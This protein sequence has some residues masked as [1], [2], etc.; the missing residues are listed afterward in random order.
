METEQLYDLFRNS[1]GVSTDSRR[2]WS[3][4]L[5][6]ALKGD[7]FNGN[8]YAAAALEAGAAYAVVDDMEVY[9]SNLSRYGE[10]LVPVEN[11]LVAL[12][13][14]AKY[15]RLKHRLPVIAITGT[16]GKTTTKELVNAVLSAKYRTVCTE[17]NLNNHIGVPLTLLKI[18]DTTD[19][20]VVEMGASAPGEIAALA[21]LVC[22]SFGLIT[23]VGR[24]HLLGFGTFEGVKKTKAELYANLERHKKIAFVN[25]DNPDL[26][27]MLGHYPSLHIV[28][29]G[30]RNNGVRIVPAGE[31]PFL[32]LFYPAPDAG[33]AVNGSYIAIQTRLIGSYNADNVLAALSVALYFDIPVAK[34]VTAI[35]EY[36]PSNNR[37]QL[38]KTERNTVVIDAYNANPASM[39]AAIENF[40][41][42]PFPDK[43][44]ILGD[45][46]ELGADSLK[47]HEKILSLALATEAENVYLVGGEFKKACN[48]ALQTK[49]KR[50]HLFENSQI[51]RE[52]LEMTRP[53]GKCFLIKGSH[54][55]RLEN[56]PE[57]L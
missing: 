29:Y 2:I 34:A 57:V 32:K 19:V 18:D 12:Q 14:L 7:N 13:Q 46:L 30:V 48:A 16:N 53:Q 27:E 31:S 47:E 26:M 3:G 20:A 39:K 38:K 50:I 45:M 5:F 23:N 11:T 56:L 35:E 22:P 15:N 28:P 1:S 51:L 8:V 10:R 36:T 42:L 9:R 17:G 52:Y 55:I 21:E 6:F 37:S 40:A 41:E 44:L 54:G 33:S 4:A 49:D 25:I 24:G 43:N